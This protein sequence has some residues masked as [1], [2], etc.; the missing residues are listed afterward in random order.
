MTRRLNQLE[1]V[2][3]IVFSSLFIINGNIL[4]VN[5]GP[6]HLSEGLVEEVY[7]LWKKSYL[8]HQTSDGK[9][10]S[11]THLKNPSIGSALNSFRKEQDEKSKLPLVIWK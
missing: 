6:T 4:E 9:L 11:G 7:K 2:L 3:Y 1:S 5:L 8:F 10:L